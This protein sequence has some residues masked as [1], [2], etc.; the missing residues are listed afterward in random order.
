MPPC[1]SL[2]MLDKGIELTEKLFIRA[3][4]VET[5]G[6]SIFKSGERMEKA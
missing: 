6:K 2:D 1:D 3:E 4:R 5:R